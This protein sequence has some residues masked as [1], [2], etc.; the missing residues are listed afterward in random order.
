M[1]F[2][3][4]MHRRT[5]ID[6]FPSMCILLFISSEYAAVTKEESQ[7]KCQNHQLKSLVF[8]P[9]PP[10]WTQGIHPIVHWPSSYRNPLQDGKSCGWYLCTPPNRSVPAILQKLSGICAI[11][12][13][14]VKIIV[15]ILDW[16]CSF[17]ISSIR[18]F[19]IL[20]FCISRKTEK[21]PAHLPISW[22]QNMWCSTY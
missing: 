19:Q 18:G 12:N 14:D 3:Y 4:S 5:T 10:S 9:A 17:S 7:S 20:S 15:M 21:S 2:C 22:K 16:Q 1:F 8:L 11:A 6:F 13:A